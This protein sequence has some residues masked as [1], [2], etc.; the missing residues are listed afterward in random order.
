MYKMARKSA[1]AI[2]ALPN[3]LPPLKRTG[4]MISSTNSTQDLVN[5][6]LYGMAF[7]ILSL[8]AVVYYVTYLYVKQVP[9]RSTQG[10]SS[11][12]PSSD[13]IIG[14]PSLYLS[15]RSAR[16]DPY[17]DPY[18][19]P[20]KNDGMYFPPDSADVRG[21]PMLVAENAPATCNSGMCGGAVG[22]GVTNAGIP[23]NVKTRGYSRDF[24]QIGLL[25][26]ERKDR[27][28]TGDTAFTDN[29]IL[30]LFGRRVLNGRDKYQYYTMSNTGAV[31]TKLPVKVRGRNCINEYGC[32]EL[33][34]GDLV[35][36]EG[37]NESFRAT[38]YE[39]GSFSYIP[40]L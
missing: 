6:L 2:P 16:Q 26:R 39:N 12:I 18:A 15:S 9:A 13:G 5:S 20:L 30:P 14:L 24:T 33:N 3:K 8:F 23:I 22:L 1:I 34:N 40:F 4:G 27:E 10:S 29:M 7:I 32:D 36:V 11:V 19:P 31:N 21:I 37:Y 35:M 17:T 28:K 25:T 38:V